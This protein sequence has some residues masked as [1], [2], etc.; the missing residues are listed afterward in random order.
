MFVTN[1]ICFPKEELISW[2][3]KSK[4]NE[5][6]QKLGQ[7]L[8]L[9][10]S[11]LFQQIFCFAELHIFVDGSANPISKRSGIGIAFE[12]SK[13]AFNHKIQLADGTTNQ[14]CELEAI[15]RALR[16]INEIADL[17]GHVSTGNTIYIWTDSMYAMDCF[18]S[19]IGK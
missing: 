5:F 8:F 17:K 12:D 7:G 16:L 2:M 10:G 3:E 15:V 9:F 4:K 1:L 14:Q 6:H 18:L 13:E 19:W 11:F